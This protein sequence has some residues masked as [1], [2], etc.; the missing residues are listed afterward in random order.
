MQGSTSAPDEVHTGS[1]V[2]S[3]KKRR[4]CAVP[5]TEIFFAERGIF[6]SIIHVSSQFLKRLTFWV[7]LV[8]HHCY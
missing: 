5:R 7:T 3:G 4:R 1:G 6:H 2:S 8:K